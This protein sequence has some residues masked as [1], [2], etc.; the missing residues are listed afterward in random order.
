MKEYPVHHIM[1]IMRMACAKVAAPHSRAG[2]REIADELL[3]DEKAEEVSQKYLHESVMLPLAKALKEG[4]EI[5]RLKASKI[6]RLCAFIEY[7]SY[8]AFVATWRKLELAVPLKTPVEKCQIIWHGD[9]DRIITPKFQSV[10]FPGQQSVFEEPL[11]L[12][13]FNIDGL[14]SGSGNTL[15][16]IA[17]SEWP[18]DVI[19]ILV[20][21][22]LRT[23][24]PNIL[25]IWVEWDEAD[26]FEKFPS[27]SR[28]N[29]LEL[30]D[31]NLTLQYLQLR[32]ELGNNNAES[33]IG[34]KTGHVYITHSG[35][36]FLGDVHVSGEYIASRDM[37]I[38][39]NNN[40]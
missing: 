35:A 31:L 7:G 14:T 28:Y 23:P 32:V 29:W 12:S 9:D 11:L 37:H 40:G 18:D 15:K 36:V 21:Q 4:S 13:H 17:I 25:P 24:K 30:F 20:K 34:L 26:L 33:V 39:I 5:L 38:T 19:A 10:F 3:T 1:V 6:E 8:V 27:L 16:V 22:L 2:M